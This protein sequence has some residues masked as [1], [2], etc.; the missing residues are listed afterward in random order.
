MVCFKSVRNQFAVSALLIAFCLALVAAQPL[1]AQ[2]KVRREISINR[3]RRIAAIVNDTYSHKYEIFVGGGY[4]RF[5][6]GKY[7]R[8]MNEGNWVVNGTRYL[9]PHFGIT[10]DV[11]GH[12]GPAELYNNQYNIYNPTVSQYTFMGGPQWRFYRTEK[13]AASVNVMGGASMGNF[14]GDSKGFAAPLL[15]MWP[16]STRAAVSGNFNV[17]YN[18][19]PNFAVRVSPTVLFNNY[20]G[21]L[22]FNKG[23]NF[24][25]VYRFG[26]Q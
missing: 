7:L 1:Q 24:G 20:G 8:R 3:Q 22:Q 25:F 2:R 15:G 12:Y 6:E 9:N 10:A 17:D 21:N 18:L 26:R 4:L 14:D 19:Y 16:T 13:L 5:Q 23:F 11:R